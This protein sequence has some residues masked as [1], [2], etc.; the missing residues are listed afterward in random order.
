MLLTVCSVFAV[1]D[2]GWAQ[3]EESRPATTT[4]DGDTGLWF[5]PTGE[6]LP[7]GNLSLSVHRTEEDFR[8][9]NT[10][11]SFW[12]ITGAVGAGRVELFGAMRVVTRIDRD[13]TPLLFAG[14]GNE[15]GGLLNEHPSVRESWT[16]NRLGDLFLGAKANL[17]SQERLQPIAFALRGTVKLPT[18][19]E[20]SGAG[21]GEYDLF[22]DAIGSREFGGLEL[23]GFGGLAVR[24]DPGVV[25][26][27]DGFRW[28]AGVGFPTRQALRATAEVYGEWLFDDSVTA[29]A[30][31]IVATDG[32]LSPAESRLKD[33]VNAA[34]GLTWQHS[35]GVLLG[36]AVTYRFGLET[37]RSAGVPRN[38]DG[39]A[40]GL[41]FRIG[42]HGGV[43]V[44]LPPPPVTAATIPAPE[45]PLPLPAPANRAPT[46]RAVCD[47]C[48]IRP[49]GAATLRAETNDPDGD[50]LSIRWSATGGTIAD[51]RA[52]I[53]RWQAEAAPGIV[54]FTVVV[55]D[56]RGAT[57]T[58]TV[59]IDVTNGD[60]YETVLFDFD[61][62]VLRREALPLLDP[63]VTMLTAN[64]E[65]RVE[66]EG[67][68]CNIGTAEYNLALGERRANA[69]RTYLM[70]RGIAGE[71]LTTISYGEERPAHDNTHAETR[72][73]NRRAVLMVRATDAEDSSR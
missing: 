19:D 8:Q 18:G 72:R 39:D 44:F 2:R 1:A 63:I 21:T 59:T 48:S 42:F 53:T 70:G 43:K 17:A 9:G 55:D 71:R 13:T 3:N 22:A 29:P 50:G 31:L 7:R 47:P 62:A 51:A 35:S 36:A 14:P 69:V 66:I 38:T 32:S 64:A 52:A 40:I 30:G 37:P 4:V 65:I 57:A 45:P 25:R 67:H 61:S 28:G 56:G 68:T 23:A 33:P 20:D 24:G 58:D 11:V 6:V 46:V 54:T 41:Q 16:G 5:V 26:I 27:S 10:S 34:F 12:P 49:G 73:L 60:A 15:A